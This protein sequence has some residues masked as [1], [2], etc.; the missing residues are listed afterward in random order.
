MVLGEYHQTVTAF[1]HRIQQDNKLR[2]FAIT[3]SNR[4]I[5][6]S[7]QKIKILGVRY[8]CI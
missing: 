4:V 5:Y 7:F 6:L 8:Y 2:M 3:V 1:W